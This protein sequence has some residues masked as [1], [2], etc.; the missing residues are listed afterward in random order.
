M[1]HRHGASWPSA[2]HCHQL[3][4]RDS[5]AALPGAIVGG[6]E[7]TGGVRVAGLDGDEARA[8]LGDAYQGVT[9]MLDGLA[10]SDFLLPTHCLGWTVSDVLYHLLGDARRALAALA[11]P[12][13]TPPRRGLHLLLRSL[14]A[15]RRRRAGPGLEYAG[16][17]RGGHGPHRSRCA[18]RSLAGD[19]AGRRQGGRARPV[20]GRRHLGSRA[21]RRG[22]RRHAGRRGGDPSPGHDCL[23]PRRV[24]PGAQLPGSH[25]A[26]PRRPARRSRRRWLGRHDLRAQGDGPPTA[27]HRRPEPAWRPGRQVPAA[28]MNRG[29]YHIR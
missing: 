1:T 26:H 18:H 23:R 25:P 3:P 24:R 28:R 10:E 21:H 2:A 20:S 5:D 12:A 15:A 14:E 9:G 4:R 17:R 27:Q 16:G 6:P 19:R 7:R 29:S 22:L 11:T 8:A 13:G